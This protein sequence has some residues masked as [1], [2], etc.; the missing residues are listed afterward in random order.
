M[1]EELIISQ[2]AYERAKERLG[3]SPSVLDKMALKAFTEGLKH[4]QTKGHLHKYITKQWFKYKHANNARVYGEN[5]FYFSNNVL[6]TVYQVPQDLRK[7]IKISQK[8]ETR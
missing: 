7:Y 8:H 6:A 4:S 1:V 3:W 2:H 5:I